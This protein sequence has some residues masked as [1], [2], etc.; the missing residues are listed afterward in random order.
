MTYFCHQIKPVFEIP[1]RPTYHKCLRIKAS[2]VFGFPI[3]TIINPKWLSGIDWCWLFVEAERSQYFG[4][5]N[6]G[7]GLPPCEFRV[8]CCVQPVYS[9]LARGMEFFFILPLST[10]PRNIIAAQCPKREKDKKLFAP[11]ALNVFYFWQSL[12]SKALPRPRLPLG[13]LPNFWHLERMEYS[14]ILVYSRPVR[15]FFSFFQG[16]KHKL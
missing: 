5:W 14:A 10:K 11:K 12:D 1:Q 13:C 8:T 15:G 6:L 3:Y 9:G 16:Y 4:L 2:I 7:G